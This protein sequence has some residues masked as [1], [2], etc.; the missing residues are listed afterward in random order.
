MNYKTRWFRIEEL[1]SQARYNDFVDREKDAIRRR[2]E[3]ISSYEVERMINSHPDVLESAAVGVPAEMGE[4]EV[5]INVA[6]KPGARLTPEALI[7]YCEPRMAYFMV[8]RY[9]EFLEA[10]PKTTT[11]KILKKILKEMGVNEKTWD[12]EKA[13]YRLK[14]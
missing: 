5:K 1:V 14:R 11:Q 10:L 7:Q 8:P 4:D 2:G 9:V 12:R 6:L 3:N 13:G